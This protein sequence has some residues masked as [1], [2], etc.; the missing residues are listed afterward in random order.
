M[1]EIAYTLETP[2]HERVLKWTPVTNADTARAYQLPRASWGFSVS[3]S[4]TFDSATVAVEGS[5]DG[6][7][8]FALTDD[9]GAIALTAAGGTQGAAMVKWIRPAFSGGGGSQSI[10]VDMLLVLGP[11]RSA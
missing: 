10:T 6:V 8:Y 3:A 5:V 7:T 9:N 4:G 1:A 11:E 2:D